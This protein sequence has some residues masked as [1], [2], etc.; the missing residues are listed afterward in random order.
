LDNFKKVNDVA[1]HDMGDELLR[2]IADFLK[3]YSSRYSGK[4]TVQSMTCRIGGD[5]FLQTLPG[6]SSQEEITV[7]AHKMLRDFAK[8]PELQRFIKE[9]SV[10]L[11]IGGAL[12]PSQTDN[13]DEVV[14][15]AD[16][17]MYTA[18]EHGKNNFAFYDKSMDEYAESQVLS[19]R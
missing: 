8:I 11:S 10:G 2:L 6:A 12:Y 5:E 15:F 3:S 17:A 18:K 19:V 9:F 16:I 4:S 14:K 13:Y 1:G 7:H